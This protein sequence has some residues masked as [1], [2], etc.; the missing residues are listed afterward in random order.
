MRSI[1]ACVN[2]NNSTNAVRMTPW[3]W[4][5]LP[6]LLAGLWFSWRYAWWRPAA[7]AAQARILMYHMIRP[8]IPGARFNKMRV[9]PAAFRA[10]VAWLAQNGWTFCFVSELI[11]TPAAPGQRRVALTFDD[12]YQ[13]NFLNALPVLREFKAKATLYPVVERP[14]GFDWSTKKKAARTSGE[15][16]REPKLS[17]AEIAAMLASG[18][19]ELGGHGLTHPN[20]PQLSAAEAEREIA[21]CKTALEQTFHA[22]VPTFCYPFGLYGPREIELVRRAGFS[23][24]TTT[25][26][27]VGAADPFQLPR[28]KI[29]GSEGLFAF[30][31]RLRTGRR[32]A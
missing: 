14:A 9:A 28:I 17:D 24:A 8:A 3:L 10:Q 32:G 22:P 5:F 4:F 23:G 11:Q 20:L 12:G 30:R 18:L 16:G 1:A 31:L 6:A 29:S 2:C 25:A 27:G 26:E 21:G 7:P 15:L 13:D 19:V